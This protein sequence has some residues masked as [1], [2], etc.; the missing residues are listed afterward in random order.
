MPF[1]TQTYVEPNRV[2]RLTETAHK[3]LAASMGKTVLI[4]LKGNKEVRGKL[5]SFDHHLNIVLED[6][7]E[8]LGEGNVRRLGQIIIR[9]DNV[10]IVSPAGSD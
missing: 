10:V 7:E 6:A 4:R 1:W 8:L 3:L 2:V 9:G 5:K